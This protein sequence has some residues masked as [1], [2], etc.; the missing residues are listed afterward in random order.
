MRITPELVFYI[1]SSLDEM[2][3]IDKALRGEG[4]NP[5]L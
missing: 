3:K 2:E 1:D 5:I 4:N